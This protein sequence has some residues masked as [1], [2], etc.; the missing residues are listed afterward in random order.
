MSSTAY[1]L[2][3]L[4][5]II[6][7]RRHWKRNYI[8]ID[9]FFNFERILH[10]IPFQNKNKLE[11]IYVQRFCIYVGNFTSV[12]WIYKEET[13]TAYDLHWI[14]LFASDPRKSGI[15][16]CS[17]IAFNLRCSCWINLSPGLKKTFFAGF[18]NLLFDDFH[19]WLLIAES[20]NN[21]GINFI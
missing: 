18:F 4:Y 2:F 10:S 7:K 17:P 14:D 21:V 1:I 3:L 19:G 6:Q 12:I 15:T 8:E 13:S 20:F 9:N 16:E 11:C 5:M